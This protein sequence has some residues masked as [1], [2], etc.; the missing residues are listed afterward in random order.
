MRKKRILGIYK[1]KELIYI[2]TNV[3]IFNTKA[4]NNNERKENLWK[5]LLKK[6]KV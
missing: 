6:L 5:S 1:L 3:I 4:K 2:I